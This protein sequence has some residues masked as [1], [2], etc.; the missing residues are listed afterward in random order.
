MQIKK[1]LERIDV[2]AFYLH[3]YI[4]YDLIL[5]YIWYNYVSAF[6]AFSRSIEIQT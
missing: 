6:Y 5:L 2:L 3:L 4:F 1:K